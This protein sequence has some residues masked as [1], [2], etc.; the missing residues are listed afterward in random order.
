MF[1]IIVRTSTIN[2][3][4]KSEI[5]KYI[6]YTQL[7]N[8]IFKHVKSKLKKKTVPTINLIQYIINAY[9]IL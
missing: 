7:K 5:V 3:S 2:N 1:F 9:I 6:F 4:L 8:T